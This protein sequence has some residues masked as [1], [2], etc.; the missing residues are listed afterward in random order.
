MMPRLLHL[1]KGTQ[2]IE[3]SDDSEDEYQLQDL[4]SALHCWQ[5]GEEEHGKVISLSP[6][7]DG[8]ET[9]SSLFCRYYTYGNRI[10]L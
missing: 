10:C 2:I 1:T 7:H 8:S 4:Q 9:A 3:D 5:C 6:G